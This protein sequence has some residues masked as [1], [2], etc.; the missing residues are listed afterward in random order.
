MSAPTYTLTTRGRELVAVRY[1]DLTCACE[2]GM[3]W[4]A[5]LKQRI[6][7]TDERGIVVA[8]VDNTGAGA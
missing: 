5:A 2:D 1:G 7:V 6:D 8:W 4:S 3:L